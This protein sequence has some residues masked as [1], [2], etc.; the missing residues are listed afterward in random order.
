MLAVLL[1][2][3]LPAHAGPTRE[4]ARV[5]GA[6]V[7][8]PVWSPDGTRLAYEANHH[9]ERR[10]ALFVGPSTGPFKPLGPPTAR[11]SVTAGF[12]TR[13]R[14]EVAHEASFSPGS[15]G[16]VVYSASNHRGDYD[17][18]VE[19][20]GAL[21]PSPGTD[22]GPSWSPDGALIAFTSAR[23]GQG[24]LY[25]ADVRDL[26]KPPRR[27]TGDPEHAE[28]SPAWAPEERRLAW[29]VHA[30]V[31]D[32]IAL[33]DD[34][35]DPSAKPRTLLPAGLGGRAGI[36]GL[37]FS[38]DG[39]RLAWY[40]TEPDR[41][42][43]DLW[44]LD[45]DSSLPVRVAEDV[46]PNASGVAWTPDGGH[47]VFVCNDDAAYDPLCA[48]AVTRPG[49]IHHLDLGTVGHGDLAVTRSPAGEAVIAWTARGRRDDRE[50]AYRRLFL[51]SLP[52]LR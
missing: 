41:S 22:G 7:Q 38:P 11:S 42:T 36:R 6:N 27:L 12:Q 52:P 46:V 31:G 3:L 21:A 37:T 29:V 9:E 51:A 35:A 24:D 33:L 32:Q 28:L 15:I 17:L 43:T 26:D 23:T 19:G 14:A 5:D 4:V 8:R 50:R 25:V 30:R 16:R 20:A 48:V 1:C 2:L 49:R 13:P 39:R 18:F 10:V 47:L 45:L 34:A 40:G 44:V